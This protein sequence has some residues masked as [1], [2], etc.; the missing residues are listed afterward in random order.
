MCY[1]NR[2]RCA[3]PASARPIIL[4]K[5]NRVLLVCAA[6]I[7]AFAGVFS[8]HQ[9]SAGSSHNVRGWAWSENIGWVSFNSADSGAGGGADYGVNID[10]VA[11]TMSG[12][13]WSEHIGW[14][15][16]NV[17]DTAGCDGC[18]GSACQA[19]V[20]PTAGGGGR[21]E[22]SGWAKVLANGGGWDGCV[23]LRGANYGVSIDPATGDFYGWA[24]SDMVLGWLSFNG[25]DAGAGGPYKVFTTASFGPIA[26][27]ECGGSSCSYGVCDNSP[28]TTWI[29][30]PP[31][32]QCP[33]CIY[34]VEDISEGNVACAYWQLS[35]PASYSYLASG[36]GQT[37]N[38]GA[39]ANKIVPGNYTLS[40]TVSDTVSSN[41][42]AGNSSTA[43]RAITIK[44][45]IDADFK[46]TFD[47]PYD[48]EGEYIESTNWQDCTSAAGKA[49]FTKRIAK[50]GVLY[51]KD[52]SSC[53]EE[54]S[55]IVNYNWK[56]TIDG[57][58]ATA[59]GEIEDL[60]IGKDNKIELKLFDNAGRE[61]C[62]DISFRARSLPKWEEV[63]I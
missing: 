8:A 35:G 62:M 20:S 26:K 60:I 13:A 32:Q 15:S 3:D 36:A 27:M 52:V 59:N 7:F 40:L 29:A 51:V 41:C 58:V 5:K 43:T 23:S 2:S 16:F 38:L 17:S 9:V 55:A 54:A 63:P 50:G 44:K 10:Q 47:N 11:W 61:N 25:A 14:I 34:S 30:Y 48:E 31:T 12:H 45:G 21:H 18:S 49:D 19:K 42:A 28:I 22:V 37:I 56:F 39:F 53:S 24:W 57:V 4:N 33:I 1:S 46:C 6:A